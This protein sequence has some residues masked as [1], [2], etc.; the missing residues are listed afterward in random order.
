M[1]ILTQRM[2]E[3]V[4]GEYQKYTVES[5]SYIREHFFGADP[6]LSSMVRSFSDE[7]LQRLRRGGHDPEKVYTAFRA[8]VEHT[9]S[10]TVILA[11][12]IKGYGLGEGGGRQ[13]HHASTEEA[14]RR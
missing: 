11:K 4:D 10:P 3:V 14:E 6:R 5:G 8:A 12:T 9:G 2:G 7:Q 13:E 1:G